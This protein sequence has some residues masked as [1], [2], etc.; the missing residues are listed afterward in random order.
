MNKSIKKFFVIGALSLVGV[1]GACGT[2]DGTTDADGNRTGRTECG[3]FGTETQYCEASTYCSDF[4]LNICSD[5]CTSDNN[6]ASNQ[7]CIKESGINVGTC[8]AIQSSGNTN[9]SNPPSGVQARCEAAIDRGV[10]CEYLTSTQAASGKAACADTSSD[11]QVLAKA[12]AD[13]ADASGSGCNNML[14]MCFG[15]GN[16]NN[17][18]PPN[19]NSGDSCSDQQGYT[20]C[21]FDA[22]FDDSCCQPGQYCSDSD[23]NECT[24]GCLSNENCAGDQTCDLSGGSPGVCMNN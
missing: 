7:E 14:E 20:L 2:D 5:G 10:A 13:C 22:Q 19:N 8:Q 24:N 23:F 11:G 3:T 12:I 9:N 18:T 17:V 15:G 4:T 16:P 1:F 6:C 21:T